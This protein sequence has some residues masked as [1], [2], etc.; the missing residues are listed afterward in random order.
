[1][2]L[3]KKTMI[4]LPEEM[5]RYLGAEASRQSKSMAEV[6]REALSEYRAHAEERSAPVFSGIIATIS[7]SDPATDVSDRVDEVLGEYFEAGADWDK[8]HSS[9]AG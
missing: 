2:T 7:D 8:E 5:H 4:Y 6:V 1:M 3:M 9:D